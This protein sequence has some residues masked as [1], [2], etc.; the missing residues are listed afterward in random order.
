MAE[1]YM[2]T[3]QFETGGDTYHPLP[4]L[5]G[6]GKVFTQSN[7]TNGTFNSVY[8]DNNLWLAGGYGLYYSTDGKS[9]TQS[10]VTRGYF[11]S[12]YY[13]NGIW[14]AGGDS[15]LYYSIDGKT[16]TQSNITNK[17]IYSVYYGNGTWVAGGDGGLYYSTDGMSWTQS[18]VTNGVSDDTFISV[19]YDNNLWVAGSGRGLWYSIDG[20]TWT[21]SNVGGYSYIYSVYYANNLWV[22]GVAEDGLYYSTDGKVWTFG[23]NCQA[24][25]FY[26]A[27]DIWVA[28]GNVA[29]WYLEPTQEKGETLGYIIGDNES[30]YPDKAVQDGYYYEKVLPALISFTINGTSYQA[31]KGM[32]WGNWVNSEYNTVGY[33]IG[34]AGGVFSSTSHYVSLGSEIQR[35]TSVIK[36]NATYYHDNSGPPDME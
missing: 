12:I 3:I 19:Y 30:D 18:N 27:N 36:P 7:I 9:W 8:Y 11:V 14:V 25:S 15:V 26:Y 4:V 21:K 2:K 29:L 16:W 20:K 1:K 23:S 28:G 24:L 13:S 32:T 5:G 6:N 17:I 34:S 22:A 10:N 35:N 31:K 33:F